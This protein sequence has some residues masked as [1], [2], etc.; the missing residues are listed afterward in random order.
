MSTTQDSALYSVAASSASSVSDGE[1]IVRISVPD[2][3]T[4]L[5]SLDPER[6]AWVEVP[7]D[8]AHRE[9]LDPFSVDVLLTDPRAQAA[10][11][12]KLAGDRDPHLPR[13]SIPAEPGVGDAVSI[14]LGL[15]FPVR[16]IPVQPD[17]DRIA[18]LDLVLKRYL[19][20]GRA[21]QPVE[22]FHSALSTL[23]HG[24]GHDL[25]QAVEYDPQVFRREPPYPGL[26]EADSA[27]RLRERLE[28]EDAECLGCSIQPW[29]GG[30]FKWPD[31]GY[32]CAG[33]RELFSSLELAAS[34]LRQDLEDAKEYAE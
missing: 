23:L 7:L 32:D 20:D 33:V 19:H 5:Q 13:L 21:T 8:L 18:E 22:P 9:E 12:Y 4:Q 1:L 29:C 30:W 24:Q 10:K 28:A 26:E 2:D 6:V 34:T 17:S 16:I 3:L 11:L 27:D 14:A 31:P 25:W 15:H